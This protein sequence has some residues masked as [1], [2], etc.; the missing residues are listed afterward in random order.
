VNF[1][2]GSP[3]DPKH[4]DRDQWTSEADQMESLVFSFGR[5]RTTSVSGFLEYLVLKEAKRQCSERADH[6]LVQNVRKSLTGEHSSDL[7]GK[8]A[9]PVAHCPKLYVA[10]R[11]KGQ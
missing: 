11:L 5:P 1:W 7:L 9:R 6:D 3:T 4:P 10:I 2:S 8:N